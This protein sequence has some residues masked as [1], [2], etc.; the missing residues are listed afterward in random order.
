[1]CTER[2][3]LSSPLA[4]PRAAL[5][6]LRIVELERGET[7]PVVTVF[8]G[9][10]EESR[11]L[12][13]LTP[14][15]RLP[16]SMLRALA[17]V[18]DE[19]HVALVAH[20]VGDDAGPVGIGRWALMPGRQSGPGA[21]GRVAEVS[22]AVV[23]AWQRR[24]VGRRLLRHLQRR[25]FAAGVTHLTGTVLLENHAIIGLLRHEL[26]VGLSGFQDG[27]GTFLVPLAAPAGG[28]AVRGGVLG[29]A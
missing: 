12:R 1:M 13:F 27:A 14:M 23:D 24:G 19:R 8:E 18:D 5:P 9:L 10:S 17:E 2:S 26:G 3:T 4:S 21:A 15:P 22:L 20:S 11:F 6:C 28:A 29:A 7:A 25:A 16:L